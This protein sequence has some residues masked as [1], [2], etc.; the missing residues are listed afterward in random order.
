TKCGLRV[1]RTRDSEVGLKTESKAGQLARL[2]SSLRRVEPE[3]KQLQSVVVVV[4]EVVLKTPVEERHGDLRRRT[5]LEARRECRIGCRVD[6]DREEE[7]LRRDVAELR[8]LGSSHRQRGNRA[9]HLL[10]CDPR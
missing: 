3:L 8:V 10:G 9:H 1:Y 5:D 2:F 4:P 6:G 7:Q